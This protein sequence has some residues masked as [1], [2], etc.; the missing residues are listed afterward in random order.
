MFT[1]AN[2][3]KWL[4]SQNNT[5]HVCRCSIELTDTEEYSQVKTVHKEGS[6]ATIDQFG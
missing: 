3:E 2:Y 6:H 4:W 1:R 5:T